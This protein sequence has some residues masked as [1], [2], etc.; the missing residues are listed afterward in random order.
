MKKILTALLLFLFTNCGIDKVKKDA[1]FYAER[2]APIGLVTLKAYPD[3]SFEFVYS[4]LGDKEIFSGYYSIM[5]D[6]LSFH[7]SGGAPPGDRTKAIIRYNKLT[8]LDT[9]HRESLE[10]SI[11][12]FRKK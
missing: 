1:I 2:E 8:Y 11:N 6:T 12:R 5:N 3:S 10:I 7:Y 9:I 4:G